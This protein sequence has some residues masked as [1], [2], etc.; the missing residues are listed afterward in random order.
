MD[1]IQ[2]LSFILQCAH[3]TLVSIQ[4]GDK[5]VRFGQGGFGA[6]M[7]DTEL[8]A[9]RDLG[10]HLAKLFQELPWV[11]SVTVEGLGEG[12][13]YNPKGLYDVYIDPLDGS[14]NYKRH[15]ELVRKGVPN[16]VSLPYSTAVTI[17]D[18]VENPCFRDIVAA[19]IIDLRTADTIV[20]Q[21]GCDT[22]MNG[23]VVKTSPVGLGSF[24]DIDLKNEIVI[25]EGYYAKNRNVVAAKFRGI[26]GWVRNPGSAAYEMMLV[27][28]GYSTA[29]IC[30]SQKMHELGAGYLLV[31][32]AGGC[33]I[34]T[35]LGEPDDLSERPYDFNTKVPVILACSKSYAEK[36]FW[37]DTF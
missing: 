19:G 32:N 24:G 8:K 27:A 14:L 36:I 20:T 10:L 3:S 6:L 25:A 2:D 23:V 34:A 13:V 5:V 30:S 11:R 4:D 35:D 21:K 17:V 33:A 29:Y 9:D 28:C 31:T 37:Y 26:D 18:T 12:I 16:Q 7:G 15:V 22:R 1:L